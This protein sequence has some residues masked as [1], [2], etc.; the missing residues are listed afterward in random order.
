MCHPRVRSAS[1][2]ALLLLAVLAAACLTPAHER[3]A[4]LTPAPRAPIAGGPAGLFTKLDGLLVGPD[5]AQGLFRESLFLHPG[6]DLAIDFPKG[7]ETRNTRATAGALSPEQDALVAL[8]FVAADTSPSASSRVP[9]HR[10]RR[11]GAV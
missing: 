4:T 5:P 3:A 1:V 9:A 11:L 7:W 2:L 10:R 6:L 8:R